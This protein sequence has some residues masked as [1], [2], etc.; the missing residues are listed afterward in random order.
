MRIRANFPTP[1]KH[2]QIFQLKKPCTTQHAHKLEKLSREQ[3]INVP[4][5]NFTSNPRMHV[6]THCLYIYIYMYIY[7]CVLYSDRYTSALSFLWH[8]DSTCARCRRGSL[9]FPI[10][11]Y[12]RCPGSCDKSRF[13]IALYGIVGAHCRRELGC[14]FVGAKAKPESTYRSFFVL[15][16]SAWRLH[17]IFIFLYILI[18]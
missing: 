10:E 14:V 15:G 7:M 17:C 8:I 1:A 6:A 9:N 13:I 5:R 16:A 12:P 2:T 18:K 3:C 11:R 4:L